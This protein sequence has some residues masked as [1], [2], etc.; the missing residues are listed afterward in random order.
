MKKILF[1]TL[2]FIGQQSF[3]QS[4]YSNSPV[5]S[6]GSDTLKLYA[7]G[8]SN[9][10]W[11]GP[12]GF[13]SL[14]QNPLILSP[15][16][17]NSG[18]YSVKIDNGQVIKVA[19]VVG[20]SNIERGL[21]NINNSFIG[22]DIHLSPNYYEPTANYFWSGPENFRS[23]E[24]SPKVYNFT[25]DNLGI[26]SLEIVDRFGCKTRYEKNVAVD[27][28]NCLYKPIL[29]ARSKNSEITHSSNSYQ[30]TGY[31]CSGSE[32][33]LGIDTTSIVLAQNDKLDWYRNGIL[34]S[35]NDF[36]IKVTEGGEYY[37]I[38]DKDGCQYNSGII[39]L[40]EKE[41][42]QPT[43][44]SNYDNPVICESSGSASLNARILNYSL[45]ANKVVYRWRRDGEIIE[46]EL[47]KYLYTNMPGSYSVE[48]KVDQC[49]ARES[50]P[51]EV[52][53]GFTPN[54]DFYVVG[55]DHDQKTIVS[56]PGLNS[57]FGLYGS[58]N[59]SFES[60][61]DDKGNEYPTYN[62]SIKVG[63]GNY[64]F[65]AGYG[66]CVVKDTIRIIEQGQFDIDTYDYLNYNFGGQGCRT[67]LFFL[68]RDT[69]L[70]G[71]PNLTIFKDNKLLL[72]NYYLST[73]TPGKYQFR[74]DDGTCFG[75]S[76]E[77]EFKG[78]GTEPL[79]KIK[80]RNSVDLCPGEFHTLT[81]ES[82]DINKIYKWYKDGEQIYKGEF[83]TISI[84]KP[85][86]YW[87][88]E[89]NGD[90]S[91]KTFSDTITIR[92]LKKESWKIDE[93]CNLESG[94]TLQ[95]DPNGSR[96][97]KDYHWFLDG[98]YIDGSKNKIQ[99]NI[100]EPGVYSIMV[101]ENNCLYEAAE[102]IAGIPFSINSEL[103]RGDKLEIEIDTTKGSFENLISPNGL[104][105]NS[106]E[107]LNSA[108]AQSGTYSFN[109]RSHMGCLYEAKEEIDIQDPILF[110]IPENQ[111]FSEGEYLSLDITVPSLTDSTETPQD[112]ELYSND[113]FIGSWYINQQ[114][115]ISQSTPVYFESSMVGDYTLKGHSYYGCTLEKKVSLSLKSSNVPI[116]RLKVANTYSTYCVEE[117]IGIPIL[118]PEGITD[119][120]FDINIRFQ[121]SKDSIR[122]TV[123]NDSAFFKYS[124]EKYL[125]L[126]RQ[127]SF[128]FEVVPR[129]AKLAYWRS[130]S[131][132]F[133]VVFGNSLTTTP[134]CDST[135]VEL[136]QKISGPFQWFRDG[137]F[138]AQTLAPYLLTK[139]PG[140]FYVSSAN[141]ARVCKNVFSMPIRVKE[142][143][144]LRTPVI[145]QNLH[146][147][148]HTGENILK[149]DNHYE[150]AGYL[151][152]WEKDGNI[153]EGET[154]INLN[155]IEDGVYKAIASYGDCETA[156]LPF[157]F[158]SS[159]FRQAPIYHSPHE[160]YYENLGKLHKE[161]CT[162]GSVS[163]AFKEDI[164]L[165][166]KKIKWYRNDS[167]IEDRHKPREKFDLSGTYRASSQNG[168]CTY[169]YDSFSIEL[170]DTLK[171]SI[172][173]YSPNPLT[174]GS[175]ADL[176]FYTINET[177][178]S[179]FQSSEVLNWYRNDSVFVD[180]NE[181]RHNR[182]PNYIDSHIYPS[183]EGSYYAFGEV[184]MIDSSASCII[185]TDTINLEVIP[186]DTTTPDSDFVVIS[187]QSYS[188]GC[189]NL[190]T[191]L[192]VTESR[193][194][195]IIWKKD[196][197]TL[198]NKLS[199]LVVEDAG[200]YEA[201]VIIKGSFNR[202]YLFNVIGKQGV[203][204]ET[205]YKESPYSFEDC[206]AG[207]LYLS[208]NDELN[209]DI[210][211]FYWYLN[212]ELVS[213]GSTS[214]TPQ[215][216]G[217]Y[218]L[219]LSLANCEMTSNK[220]VINKQE[221]EKIFFSD[222]VQ[223]LCNGDLL[224]LE[225]ANDEDVNLIWAV[226]DNVISI[227]SSNRL[228]VTSTGTYTPILNENGCLYS[229]EPINVQNL[230]YPEEISI[231]GD[232]L[233][234]PGSIAQINIFPVSEGV[235]YTVFRD[236]LE[237]I[238]S[239][240][241]EFVVDHPA[242][243]QAVFEKGNCKSTSNLFTVTK[244]IENKL[245]AESTILCLDSNI[246]I[247]IEDPRIVSFQWYKDGQL[248]SDINTT[249][250]TVNSA[251]MY[252]STI[253]SGECITYSDTILIEKAEI[254]EGSIFGNQEVS[255]GD[256]ATLDISING[257]A[258]PWEIVL[259]DGTILNTEQAQYQYHFI[260]TQSETFTIATLS[261][262]C[263]EGQFSGSA[264]V[265]VLVL[266]SEED[267]QVLV[268]PN[269][270]SS[271]ILINHTNL[272][273]INL[274]NSQGKV[275]KP[276]VELSKDYTKIDIRQIPSGIY[277]L[278]F[279]KEDQ[280]ISRKVLKL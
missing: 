215:V 51:L 272:E 23:T 38:L 72:T 12:N 69:Y 275:L 146:E 41:A 218:H 157:T 134:K 145:S 40:I 48:V 269:P 203:Q 31:F 243:Y 207:G 252:Y 3:A 190:A 278:N 168:N 121:Q 87:V 160:N 68:S 61:T 197:V 14:E 141:N 254:S 255:Y 271:F 175:N 240:E 196:G 142:E 65:S 172:E 206:F 95:I 155:V 92:N 84:D 227:N 258:G 81:L 118:I 279:L 268:Y 237:L 257:N 234:C 49:E 225:P 17:K 19:T 202:K 123:R 98:S 1:Y 46:D 169:I 21:T 129:S 178:N 163:I 210:K 89:E 239:V 198:D 62:P 122:G 20:S 91:C 103:C 152:R 52:K 128:Y 166:A 220:I 205:A 9:Y 158:K 228:E 265:K 27:D 74:Y 256:S 182:S 194:V 16:E 223:Y 248:Q 102:N 217:T 45:L 250:Y 242:V 216:A 192:K 193:K 148:C 100:S 213:V 266:A 238:D 109:S 184:I 54:H 71:N 5:C 78:D 162:G 144:K 174:H 83:F 58:S 133:S 13:T 186:P 59:S 26:Y 253:A 112:F 11:S 211:D 159:P 231:S 125:E 259:S 119:S 56:C 33:E 132:S 4:A 115:E 212:D 274:I 249:T 181:Y 138:F 161:V 85:G 177:N 64:Y 191:I 185:A 96:L 66:N 25:I 82:Y 126:N 110:Y 86:N 53:K 261:D 140:E 90:E 60:I 224:E 70:Y 195:D 44:T 262:I 101:S 179:T 171:T 209:S 222:H 39:R 117:E 76:D 80:G 154:S 34:L 94:G 47:E 79:L 214:F 114:G 232:S 188:L 267:D 247:S 147:Y 113:Q 180:P 127:T 200:I 7:E 137:E 43:V 201:F 2:L 170:K 164:N 156:S 151:Y 120:D 173:I 167:L 204:I 88:E 221:P 153:L 108:T 235:N 143:K 37:F 77:F 236:G 22:R 8:G 116:V 226:N 244:E 75:T 277:H 233:F 199:E 189:N 6:D 24:I 67:S 246:D 176:N 131:S 270:S 208:L 229:L 165:P 93:Q 97:N 29:Y 276:K 273:A 10:E 260:P 251:G 241:S 230:S 280:K 104:V 15:N 32:V 187:T 28:P 111:E 124:L 130:Y 263:G 139:V 99:L 30:S 136:T 245:R 63:P 18:E 183:K 219:N 73:L 35:Y 57:E 135:L 42:F 107:Q 50:F 106:I 36:S 264:D 150:N 105:F 149:I 55:Y